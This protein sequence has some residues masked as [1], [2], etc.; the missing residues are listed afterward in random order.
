MIEKTGIPVGNTFP[1]FS[2]FVYGGVNYEPYRPLFE[3]LVGRK[4][5]SIELFPA[6]EGFFAYQDQQND[7]GLLLLLNNQI[8]YEFIKA[9]EFGE[10]NQKRKNNLQRIRK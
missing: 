3:K 8:F 9:D 6:S 5:D 2:L 7:K 4:L 1:D 10:Q